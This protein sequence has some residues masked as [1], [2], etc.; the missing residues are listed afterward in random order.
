MAFIP[1]SKLRQ[2]ADAHLDE[3]K[4]FL[5]DLLKI[6]SVYGKEAEAQRYVRDSF[7]KIGCRVRQVPI[8]EGLRRDPEYSHTDHPVSSRGRPNIVIDAGG[9]GEGRSIIL[10][11]HVDVVPAGSW[12]KAFDPT[13]ERDYVIGRGA[14]DCKGQIAALYLLLHMMKELGVEPRSRVTV[15]IVVEEE[16]GGNGSLSLI[17]QGYSADGVVVLEA[18]D[19]T[20]CPANR[21]AVWFRATVRGKPVHMARKTTGVSAIDKSVELMRLLYEYEAELAQGSRGQP[22]F[23]EYEQ[24]VQ[25]NIGRLAAGDWPSTVPGLA[26]MEGG[27]GFLPNKDLETVKRELLSL[28]AKGDE[29][30]AAH[31]TVEFPALHNDS[32]QIPIA[33]PLV[34]EMVESCK[35]VG[36]QTRIRG[37]IASCDARLFNRVGGMPTIVFGAGPIEQAHSDGERVKVGDLVLEACALFEFL[38]NWAGFRTLRPT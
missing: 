26:V 30:L 34:Q 17:R 38:H 6:P 15:Q 28:P 27:V 2:C 1:S 18:T 5:L 29:W 12:A 21:G 4:A 35:R 14:V 36:I 24:P 23:A 9:H 20:V 3:T 10:N 31:T 11:T 37:L 13:V 16:I 7:R 22:L 8:E 25:V 33:H 32:Y 19:L